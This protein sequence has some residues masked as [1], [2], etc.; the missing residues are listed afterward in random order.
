MPDFT[1]R[2][3]TTQGIISQ[4]LH[5]KWIFTSDIFWVSSLIWS[6]MDWGFCYI[7][8]WSLR[9]VFL[10]YERLCS[11][12]YCTISSQRSIK[13]QPAP[14]THF[15]I[16]M[17]TVNVRFLLKAVFKATT[18]RIFNQLSRLLAFGFCAGCTVPSYLGPKTS[19]LVGGQQQSALQAK[20]A[21]P[22]IQ[23][24][25]PFVLAFFNSS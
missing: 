3:L 1:D 14:T 13:Q 15:N 9:W 8:V 19:S 6:N 11:T 21:I 23:Q 10:C 20:A 7:F 18:S 22:A 5:Y 25:R 12:L 16:Q 24:C 2:A 17:Y 4:N